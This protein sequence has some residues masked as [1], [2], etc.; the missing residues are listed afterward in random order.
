MFWLGFSGLPRRIHDYPVVFMG[1]QGMASV[2][3]FV[4]LT[5]LLFFFFMMLDS[6]I[7]RKIAIPSTLGMPRWHKRVI[8]Y[9]FKIRY[10]QNINKQMSYLPNMHIRRYLIR[11]Y[12]T[13][14]EFF[15]K[16]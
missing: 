14:Y 4:T 13:E 10:L 16:F 5:G 1:W 2:G 11:S 7:E 15:K 8:Y 9:I 3:H 12:F 6:H